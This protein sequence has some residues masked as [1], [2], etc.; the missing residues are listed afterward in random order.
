MSTENRQS[1]LFVFLDDDEDLQAEIAFPDMVADIAQEDILE[2]CSLTDESQ[3][4]SDEYQVTEVKEHLTARHDM[5]NDLMGYDYQRVVY[6]MP[7]HAPD[8]DTIDS[9]MDEP[10][11][12][13]TT[14]TNIYRKK[15]VE[16]QA[17]QW[18]KNGDHP[19]DKIGEVIVLDG[20][21]V[22]TRIEG[23]VVRFFRHP[24]ISGQK[25]CEHCGI[26]MDEHGWI[27]TLEGGHI[28]CPGD[29]VI[30]GVKGEWYPCKP[31]I[32]KMTYDGPIKS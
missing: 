10:K 19:D 12:S 6:L 1:T 25:K 26:F 28:V 11:H 7:Y 31:D 23:V 17:V 20:G 27:E 21:E 29:Y 3:P 5:K 18:F 13:T 4:E 32:F 8:L 9:W 24:E 15:P 22:F 16:V 2:F 14:D 30:T